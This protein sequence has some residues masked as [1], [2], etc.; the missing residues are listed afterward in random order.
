MVVPPPAFTPPPLL[1]TLD[2]PGRRWERNEAASFMMSWF[3]NRLGIDLTADV[4]EDGE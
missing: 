4:K 1:P 2:S 3:M